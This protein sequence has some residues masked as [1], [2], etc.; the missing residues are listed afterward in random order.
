MAHDYQNGWTEKDQLLENLQE[1]EHYRDQYRDAL[2]T[3]LALIG[4]LMSYDNWLAYPPNLADRVE[5]F[6]APFDAEG[7]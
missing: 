7:L 2:N 3:A 6:M 4:E 5:E 1:A